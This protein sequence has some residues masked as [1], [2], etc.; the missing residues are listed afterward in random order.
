MVS[1][2]FFN[3]ISA[4]QVKKCALGRK[5]TAFLHS[6]YWQIAFVHLHVRKNAQER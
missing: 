5:G 2:G 3:K 1:A 6:D 4:F